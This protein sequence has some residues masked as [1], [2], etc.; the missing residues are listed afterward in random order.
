MSTVAPPS[1]LRTSAQLSKTMDATISLVLSV[2]LAQ[3]PDDKKAPVIA[4]VEGYM[5]QMHGLK[6]EVMGGFLGD[7]IVPYR[8]IK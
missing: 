4:E 6:S 3:L 8:I 7:M 2:T 5:A 1:P